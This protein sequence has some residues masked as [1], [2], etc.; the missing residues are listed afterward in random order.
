MGIKNNVAMTLTKSHVVY[1]DNYY[2]SL[3][4]VTELKIAETGVTGTVSDNRKHLPLNI[5]PASNC[6]KW[7]EPASILEDI[8][9][10][11][12]GLALCQMCP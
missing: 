10:D 9:H 8:P 5:K 4:L 6:P 2:T 1:M 3:K 12:V 11:C 7:E